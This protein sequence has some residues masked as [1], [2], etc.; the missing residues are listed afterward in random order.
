VGNEGT[1]AVGGVLGNTAA[2]LTAVGFVFVL[3][4]FLR[5]FFEFEDDDE[6]DEDEPD[7]EPEEDEEDEPELPPFFPFFPLRF[8]PPALVEPDED[9]PFAPD[10]AEDAAPP[11]AAEP[12]PVEFDE[13]EPAAAAAAPPLWSFFRYSSAAVAA[14]EA[15]EAA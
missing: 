14:R 6:E 9:A 7:D 11:V 8:F 4:R 15:R 12:E 1:G 5:C 3:R 13:A 10:D 2:P